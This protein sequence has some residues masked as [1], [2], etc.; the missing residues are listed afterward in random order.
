[1]WHSDYV[2]HVDE[3]GLCGSFEDFL[4]KIDFKILG[5]TKD[6]WK[7]STNALKAVFHRIWIGYCHRHCLK[8]FRYALSKYQEQSKC[9]DQEVTRLYKKF[10]KVLKTSTSKVNLEIKLK[11]LDDD[12]FSGSPYKTVQVVKKM[13]GI[14]CKPLI[15]A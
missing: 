2:D 15:H 13:L 10:K 9:T 11:T 12:A 1:V 3:E 6:K 7:A 4:Q 5:V 8:K 14:L